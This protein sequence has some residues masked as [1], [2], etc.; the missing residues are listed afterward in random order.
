MVPKGI[1]E[2]ITL[3]CIKYTIITVYNYNSGKPT[4]KNLFETK[5]SMSNGYFQTGTRI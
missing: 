1:I 5:N 2:Y 4:G 3:V